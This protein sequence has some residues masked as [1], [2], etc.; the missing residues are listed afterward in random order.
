MLPLYISYKNKD[1]S[2]SISTYTGVKKYFI[3]VLASYIFYENIFQNILSLWY[4]NIR[5]IEKYYSFIFR[6]TVEER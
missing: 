1:K 3:Y 6:N 5:E 4:K 2:N